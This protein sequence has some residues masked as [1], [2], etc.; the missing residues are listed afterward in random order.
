VSRRIAARLL[1]GPFAFLIG[2]VIDLLAFAVAALRAR[3]RHVN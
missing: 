1:T 3:G 2:G